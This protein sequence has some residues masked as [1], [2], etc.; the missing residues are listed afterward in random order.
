MSNPW[1]L[2]F[3]IRFGQSRCY[4]RMDKEINVDNNC[5]FFKG[6]RLNTNLPIYLVKGSFMEVFDCVLFSIATEESQ[7][8]HVPMDL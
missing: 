3:W 4:G 1:R 5:N 7:I 2:D 8:D 6:I